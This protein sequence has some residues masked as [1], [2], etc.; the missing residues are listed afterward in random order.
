MVRMT[1]R[2]LD[3]LVKEIAT[4]NTHSSVNLSLRD[5]QE[6]INKITGKTPNTTKLAVSMRRA[7]LEVSESKKRWVWKHNAGRYE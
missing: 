4:K 1:Q 5:I 3:D 2:E 6:M 7:G